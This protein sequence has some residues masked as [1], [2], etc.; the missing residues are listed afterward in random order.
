MRKLND[1]PL[2]A[3]MIIAPA[4]MLLAMLAMAWMAAGQSAEQRARLSQLDTV[5]F[6]RLRGA[7]TVSEA[8]TS[9][10]GELYHLMSVAANE[11]DQKRRSDMSDALV[12]QMSGTEAQLKTLDAILDAGTRSRF[13]AI[14]QTFAGYKTAALQVADMTKTDAAYGAMMM[15]DADAQFQKLHQLLQDFVTS[16]QQE[17]AAVAVQMVAAMDR[18]RLG[19]LA[20]LGGA[21][22]IS[23][24]AVFLMSRLTARPVLTLTRSMAAL[25]DGDTAIDVPGRA[26]RDEV[27]AMAR[28]VQVFKETAITAAGHTA[29]RER[30]RVEQQQRVERLGGLAATF[31]ETASSALQTVS[32]AAGEMRTTA[33]A[34]AENAEETNRQAGAAAHASERT[35]ANVQTV[36]TSAEELSSTV[37]EIGRQVAE[38]TRIAGKA[39]E[40]TSR[41]AATVH[42]LAEAAQK[43]GAVVSLINAIANQ[44]NLLALNAT[45]EAARAGEA[46]K[47]FAVVASEVK[48]LASQTAKATEDITAQ[49]ANMQGATNET[50]SAIGAIGATI[51]EMNKIAASIAGAIEEQGAATREIARNVQEAAALTGEVSANIGGVTGAAAKT[52]S[53]SHR[54]LDA[55]SRLAERSEALRA[56]ITRFLTALKAA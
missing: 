44:T 38:S 39:V 50:V 40:E 54:V 52:G 29:E 32:E 19:F 15:G 8:V 51:D 41:S 34:M 43:I 49:V 42:K 1:L 16:L 33:G 6:E 13:A 21:I 17:R 46:G 5:V 31:D 23:A 25:A 37:A 18:A 56:E 9:F 30:Q 11:T 3:K 24:A 7:M 27:G 36:A 4:L 2:W 45:I 12:G 48:S 26:R 28:A 35:A 53:A 47:G 20:L 22:A 55:S 10:R 14:G